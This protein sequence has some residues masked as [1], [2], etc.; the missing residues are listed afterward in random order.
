MRKLRAF[1][2]MEALLSLA[3]FLMVMSL[4]AS[5]LNAAWKAEKHFGEQDRTQELALSVLYR[6][7]FEVRSANRLLTV[8]P[9]TLE[10]ESP[11]WH[12]REQE[13]PPPPTPFPTSW[14]PGSPAFQMRIRYTLT[15]VHLERTLWAESSSWNNRLLSDCRAF[16][17]TQLHP[18]QL[19]LALTFL[20]KGQD[21]VF[22][23]KA[24]LPAPWWSPP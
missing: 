12:L 18:H 19:E 14:T 20:S 7:A 17:V 24:N 13:F 16:R 15:G 1:T 22:S 23:L 8:G 9:S 21:K 10:F 3:L 2:L 4:T 11:D 5:L 6:M